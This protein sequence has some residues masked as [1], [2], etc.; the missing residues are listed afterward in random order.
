MMAA[1]KHGCY[2]G[3]GPARK[4][5]IKL[6]KS[7]ESSGI[8]GKKPAENAQKMKTTGMKTGGKA[9]QPK[10]QFVNAAGRQIDQKISERERR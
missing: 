3:G 9:E 1:V 2:W 6:I 7:T 10:W 5:T 8:S 4:T